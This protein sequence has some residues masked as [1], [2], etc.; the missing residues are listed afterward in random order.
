MICRCAGTAFRAGAGGC[1][2][3]LSVG[4][5]GWAGVTSGCGSGEVA[6]AGAG[7]AG[8]ASLTCAGGFFLG[9]EG[10]I[11]VARGVG[12]EATGGG[13]AGASFSRR[14]CKIG[15]SAGGAGASVQ[16]GANSDRCSSR[17]RSSAASKGA[18]RRRRGRRSHGR[19]IGGRGLRSVQS[20][21][22]QPC[23]Q[24]RPA[25]FQPSTVRRPVALSMLPSKP[26]NTL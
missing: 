2:F 18:W 9:A 17:D 24:G 16:R 7:A 21:R 19:D 8:F 10:V 6:G 4:A 11:F 26:P 20:R 12:L 1:V 22:A 14:A 25:F 23:R 15:S 13:V 3:A 5:L